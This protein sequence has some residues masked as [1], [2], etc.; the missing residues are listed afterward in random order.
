MQR[1]KQ[2]ALAFLLGAVLVGG[3]VGFSADRVFRSND[4]S[5]AARRQA[6]YD[7]LDLKDNQRAALD[8][9]FDT[10][11]C[12]LDALLKPLQPAL[13]SIK[14]S[15]RAQM[16]AILTPEQR[17]RLEARRKD[18]DAKRDTERKHIKAACKK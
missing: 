2:Q 5:I 8:S 15:R 9:V 7:D 17:V 16:N 3:V 1:P 11:N 6:L 10:S 18:D 4:N 13:D 14:A 12:Q